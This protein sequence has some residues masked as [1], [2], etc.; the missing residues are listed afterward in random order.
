MSATDNLHIAISNEI[1]APVS[2]LYQCCICNERDF[3]TP[4]TGSF[5]QSLVHG[6]M[7][8]EGPLT[9]TNALG[10]RPFNVVLL[11]NLVAGGLTSPGVNK[12]EATLT[13]CTCLGPCLYHTSKYTTLQTYPPL[14]VALACA[15]ERG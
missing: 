11:G 1:I 3:P 5:T 6:W 13:A 10:V 15:T 4:Q 7:R 12:Y 8:G 9:W 14:G 2:V